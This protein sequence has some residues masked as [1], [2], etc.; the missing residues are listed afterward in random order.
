M[1]PLF[2]NQN[3]YMGQ[4][5]NNVTPMG[6]GATAPTNNG[7]GGMIEKMIFN[8][9]YKS[10]PQFRQLADSVQGQTPEQAFQERG[11]DMNQFMN[12]DPNTIRQMLGF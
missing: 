6:Q 9:L 10:N 5:H 12:V 11:L 3:N 4:T 1:N 7:P 8:N 2:N